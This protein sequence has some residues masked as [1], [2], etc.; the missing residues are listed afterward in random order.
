MPDL[1]I[2]FLS[3]FILSVIICRFYF[4]TK[5]NKT[6]AKCEQTSHKTELYNYSFRNSKSERNISSSF[7][8]YG[9]HVVSVNPFEI[10]I[11]RISNFREKLSAR[12]IIIAKAKKLATEKMISMSGNS[13]QISNIK[14]EI[15]YIGHGVCEIFTYGTAFYSKPA[16][17][18]KTPSAAP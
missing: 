5:K 3:A 12:E 17:S 14:Y 13:N 2:Y 4:S 8:V 7:M 15:N 6:A 18:E 9:S 1:E 16:S 11:A 10:L